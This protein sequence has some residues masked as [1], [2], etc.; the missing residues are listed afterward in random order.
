M[1]E[2]CLKNIN[3]HPPPAPYGS[4]DFDGAIP[5]HNVHVSTFLSGVEQKLFPYGY[6]AEYKQFGSE[7]QESCIPISAN[8]LFCYL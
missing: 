2:Q 4:T 8:S 3:T 7:I 6:R 1:L 5:V